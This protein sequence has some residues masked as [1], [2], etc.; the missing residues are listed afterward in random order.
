MDGARIALLDASADDLRYVAHVY[1][2]AMAGVFQRAGIGLR[3]QADLLAAQWN[4]AE[5][6]LI[7]VDGQRVGWVQ[8]AAAEGGHFIRNF[9]IDPDAQRQ[10]IGSAVLRRLT[11]TA[12]QAQQV[13]TLSVAHGNP[14]RALYERFGFRIT[15]D[16][17]Q[18]HHMR[19]NPE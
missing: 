14:A 17:A 10:G 11:G 2:R 16:D 13:L 19:R 5:I 1:G 12:D 6:R 15:H 4:P 8:L 18:H 3:Q 7:C 9:C